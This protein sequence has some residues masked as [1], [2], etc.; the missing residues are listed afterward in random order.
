MPLD[1]NAL[2]ELRALDPDGSSGLVA[3][4]IE[5]YMEDTNSI[6]AKIKTAIASADA[7]TMAREAHS[8]KSTSRSV[9]AL[10]LGDLAADM[11]KIGRT[12]TIDG[13]AAALDGMVAEYKAVEPA[14]RE[15]GKP[16][17]QV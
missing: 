8:L 7:T 12:G 6:F 5:S 2:E 4:V 15:A 14:L 10:H 11:E 17:Q 13:C 9:G 1:Q 3:Q 16:A